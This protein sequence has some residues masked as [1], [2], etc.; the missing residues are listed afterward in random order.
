MS[1][2]SARRLVLML[3]LLLGIDFACPQLPGAVAFEVEDSVEGRPT[4]WRHVDHAPPV[5]TP[6]AGLNRGSVT[7]SRPLISKPLPGARG[8]SHVQRGRSSRSSTFL[9]DE[10]SQSLLEDH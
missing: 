1:A 6:A 7:D 10:S 9:V 8:A 5:V 3:V 2:M 4:S